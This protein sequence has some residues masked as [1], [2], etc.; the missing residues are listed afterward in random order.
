MIPVQLKPF[1]AA[2]HR[3]IRFDLW[4]G[5]PSY[6]VQY[7]TQIRFFFNVWVYR[8][9]VMWCQNS[10]TSPTSTCFQQ[11]VQEQRCFKPLHYI[12]GSVWVAEDRQLNQRS[13]TPSAHAA[14]SK[15]T[16]CSHWCLYSYKYEQ[17]LRKKKPDLKTH[18]IGVCVLS[19]D[20]LVDPLFGSCWWPPHLQ[21]I[22]LFGSPF[23]NWF[24]RRLTYA[25]FLLLSE[26]TAS[27]GRR[28]SLMFFITHWSSSL[29]QG[30]PTPFS[31]VFCE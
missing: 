9:T 27:P 18:Q 1:I 30:A 8:C 21:L 3:H 31:S 24:W 5:A 16:K 15:T 23:F 14:C 17:P 20:G 4:F 29:F 7:L 13:W 25:C 12:Y 6:V 22:S 11:S 19:L 10:T 26:V 28:A 2:I